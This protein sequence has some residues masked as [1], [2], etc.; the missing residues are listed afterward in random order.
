LFGS[1]GLILAVFVKDNSKL[2]RVLDG[3]A[4]PYIVRI[5]AGLLHSEQRTRV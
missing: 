5:D 2:V 3:E 1:P 4:Q